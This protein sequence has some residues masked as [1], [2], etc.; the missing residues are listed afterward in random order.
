M[1][2]VVHLFVPQ[3]SI[4]FA[5]IVAEVFPYHLFIGTY[6]IACTTDTS[7]FLEA[8]CLSITTILFQQ[9][10]LKGFAHQ[11]AW[12]KASYQIPD[13]TPPPPSVSQTSLHWL[14][15]NLQGST[16]LCLFFHTACTEGIHPSADP[17]VSQASL[18]QTKES[19]QQLQ[20]WLNVFFDKWYPFSPLVVTQA[21]FNN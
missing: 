17:S 6:S 21:K 3:P 16:G 19:F 1:G 9:A 13:P 7:N 2:T 4:Q 15:Q 10:A 11:Q 12:V 20:V 14:I 5:H 8:H 18:W